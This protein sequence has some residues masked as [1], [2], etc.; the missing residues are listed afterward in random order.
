VRASKILLAL[1][2][3]WHDFYLKN[4]ASK[5]SDA[6]AKFQMRQAKSLTLMIFYMPRKKNA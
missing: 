4:C 2:F 5:I 1:V 3:C 6:P